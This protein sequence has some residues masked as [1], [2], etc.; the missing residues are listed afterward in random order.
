MNLLAPLDGARYLLKGLGLLSRPGIKRYVIVPMLVNFV[1]FSLL[2][3]LG[4]H[5]M[6]SLVD[7]LM[8]TLP[9]WLWWLSWLFWLLF[10]LAALIIV[11]Y[12]FSI[13]ANLIA[14]PFNGQLAEAVAYQLSGK[15][16]AAPGSF[17]D[18]IKDFVPAM[19]AELHKLGYMALWFIPL[20]LLFLIPGINLFAPFI[21]AIFGAWLLALEYLDYPL[22]NRGLK[23]K[24]QRQLAR[25]KRFC[26]LGFGGL[27]TVATLIPVVNFI[28]MPA[29]V[30]G[31]TALSLD[32]FNGRDNRADA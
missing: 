10:G 31:A 7:S 16:T 5:Y 28:V 18:A 25:G 27:V 29:A 19:L 8:P 17:S 12:S 9:D 15:T 1:V 32:K 20:L 4:I 22:A 26:L 24:Q 11:F 6:G 13:V 2:I 14:A 3:W 21:W 23:F 30:A